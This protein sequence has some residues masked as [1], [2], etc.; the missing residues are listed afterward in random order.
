MNAEGDI[1]AQTRYARSV[2]A[3]RAALVAAG[4]KPPTRKASLRS[5][6]GGSLLGNE[7]VKALSPRE[8]RQQ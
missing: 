7:L 5:P 4:L 6:G 2:L 8:K 3:Y 1:G